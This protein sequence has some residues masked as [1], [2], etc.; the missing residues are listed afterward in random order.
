M[1]AALPVAEKREILNNKLADFEDKILEEFDN[2]LGDRIGAVL[3][4]FETE[5]RFVHTINAAA[6]RQSFTTTTKVLVDV[7]TEDIVTP[8]IEE[9][10]RQVLRDNLNGLAENLEYYHHFDGPD[11]PG[12]DEDEGDEDFTGLGVITTVFG[13]Q[14]GG[15]RRA[16]TRKSKRTM[17]RAVKRAV[18]R[19]VSK[20]TRKSNKRRAATHKRRA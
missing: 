20:K 15:R 7:R 6:A 10:V 17:K 12:V 3:N 18:K 14:N 16:A 4:G 19:S 1:N 8:E 13:A 9:Q 11:A 5:F 2:L